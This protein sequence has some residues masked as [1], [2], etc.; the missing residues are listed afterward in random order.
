MAE[1]ASADSGA[2]GGHHLRRAALALAIVLALLEVA[3]LL[4]GNSFL[5]G[6]W[7]PEAVNRKPEK[8]S[9]T[10]EGGWTLLPGLLHV[11]DLH[12]RGQTRRARWS[13]HVDSGTLQVALPAL[14]R[15]HFRLQGASARG[16][17][18][19]VDMLPKPDTP[20][21]PAKAR[22]GWRVTL[23]DV[24][25]SEIRS[26]RVGDLHLETAGTDVG[27]GADTE[28]ETASDTASETASAGEP[29]TGSA[30]GAGTVAGSGS[31]RGS[32]F[33]EIRGPMRLDLEHLRVSGATLLA[34][35]P[36]EEPDA[37]GD[38]AAGPETPH[39]LRYPPDAEVV[40]RDIVARDV[41]LGLDFAVHRFVASRQDRDEFLAAARSNLEVGARVESLAFL[42]PWLSSVPWLA[43]RGGGDL[44]GRVSLADGALSPGSHLSLT[45]S[46]LAADFF[47]FRATGAGRLEA[48][49]PAAGGE[50]VRGEPAASPFDL[51]LHLDRYRVERATRRRGRSR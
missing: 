37:H 23:D 32:V 40:A 21:P 34:F 42:D 15:R 38:E 48:S 9:A 13:A 31:A 20:R 39:R 50:G 46:Q 8:F 49:V 4:V 30:S 22:R 2:A 12:L 19:A 17:E 44:A 28:S 3:Y 6:E 26:L 7:G 36:E 29:D 27:A 10:W 25:L 11:R 47:D 18:V 16:V 51:A 43:L 41:E 33:F 14:A 35:D 24:D 1:P 45:A 5:R